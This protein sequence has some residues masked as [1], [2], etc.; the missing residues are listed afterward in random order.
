MA[1]GETLRQDAKLKYRFFELPEKVRA[2]H[3][4][5]FARLCDEHRWHEAEMMVERLEKQPRG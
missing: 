4:A 2:G 5:E 1:S 3:Y